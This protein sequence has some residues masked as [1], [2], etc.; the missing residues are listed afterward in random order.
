MTTDQAQATI[1][2]MT[3]NTFNEEE[4]EDSSSVSATESISNAAVPRPIKVNP[5]VILAQS[6]T[7]V[8]QDFPS[9][10]IFH[11]LDVP[12]GETTFQVNGEIFQGQEY[13]REGR[14]PLETS[15]RRELRND[16]LQSLHKEW[17]RFL[18]DDLDGEDTR[19]ATCYDKR[20]THH[21]DS[22]IAKRREDS[23]TGD[24]YIE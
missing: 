5:N 1:A 10:V 12:L 21:D 14:P 11:I 2:T 17:I 9:P 3:M 19:E 15:Y 7:A 16:N 13:L 20:L 6:D 22:S 18:I 23:F 24:E 4:L 8:S